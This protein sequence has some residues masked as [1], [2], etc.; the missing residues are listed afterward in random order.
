MGLTERVL[1]QDGTFFDILDAIAENGVEAADAL[2]ERL[3]TAT[4][5]RVHTEKIPVAGT[6]SWLTYRGL[7]MVI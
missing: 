4:D 2:D 6:I 7:L 1:P 3:Q 5:P